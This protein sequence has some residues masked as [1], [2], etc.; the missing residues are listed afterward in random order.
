MASLFPGSSHVYQLGLD[1][2]SDDTVWRYAGTA[3]LMR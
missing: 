1:R 3:P 2:S